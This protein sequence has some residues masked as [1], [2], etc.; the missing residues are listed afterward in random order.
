MTGL[1]DDVLNILAESIYLHMSGATGATGHL[2]DFGGGTFTLD[3][4]RER[5]K[6]ITS[7]P[8][9]KYIINESNGPR[10][11]SIIFMNET[12]KTVLI[13]NPNQI[14]AP[15]VDHAGN[16]TR[17]LQDGLAG[18]MYRVPNLDASGQAVSKSGRPYTDGDVRKAWKDEWK[19]LANGIV[20][21]FAQGGE[22]ITREQVQVHNI[23]PEHPDPEWAARIGQKKNEMVGGLARAR[24]D[25]A[26]HAGHSST[27]DNPNEGLTAPGQGLDPQD[28]GL[29]SIAADPKGNIVH[30]YDPATNSITTFNRDTGASTIERFEN[31]ESGKTKFGQLIKD[32]ASSTG[33]MPK[34]IQGGLAAVDDAIRSGSSLWG[35]IAEHAGHAVRF[36]GRLAKV[37][38]PLGILGA[39]AEAAEMEK[40]LQD[41]IK[42]DLLD[43]S[44]AA[45]YRAIVAGSVLQATA[46]PTLVGG[47]AAVQIAYDKWCKK[48]GVEDALREQLKPGSLIESVTGRPLIDP[49]GGERER[50]IVYVGFDGG[51]PP[52]GRQDGPLG[53]VVPIESVYVS[54]RPVYEGA[55]QAGF[56]S[57]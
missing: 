7:D 51:G 41:A 46:D 39:G 3:D 16:L 23:N 4:V 35:K 26:S 8:N 17:D 30:T 11:G 57:P 24:A 25:I 21:D 18:T 10:A 43:E 50:P 1:P 38:G 40:H 2:S 19:R 29:V 6:Q 5:I 9:T 22:N 47:E 42:F 15:I 27:A 31:A 53:G 34:L 36:L 20:A 32:A 55:P 28:V 37:L 44:A 33:E 12:T 14:G 45:E 52:V 48:Y 54:P 13:F 49:D 56:M